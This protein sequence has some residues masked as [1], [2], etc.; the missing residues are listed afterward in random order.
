L[1]PLPIDERRVGKLADECDRIDA[2]TPRLTGWKERQAT[3]YANLARAC[4]QAAVN[5]R[6]AA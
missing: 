2:E 4:D 6:G 5:A 1:K 3:A